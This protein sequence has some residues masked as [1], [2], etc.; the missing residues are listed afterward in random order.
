MAQT[1]ADLRSENARLRATLAG[2]TANESASVGSPSQI[3]DY[4]RGRHNIAAM[5]QE[6]FFAV[7]LSPH[8]KP[9]AAPVV[10]IGTVARVDMH[11]R[12]V[13]REAIS[14]NAHS[15]VIA[16]NHPSGDPRPSGADREL[17]RRMVECGK[18]MGIPVL[19]HVV[20]AVGEHYSFA[21]H[22]EICA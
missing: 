13:F 16:H 9:I 12:D 22:G 2:L 5:A 7:L 11:P 1:K 21:A 18:L 4:I 14:Q 8:Q 20:L 19:D 3:A 15:I 10:A 17:T 6:H